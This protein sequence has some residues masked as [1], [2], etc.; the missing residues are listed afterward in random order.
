MG[1]SRRGAALPRSRSR[2]IISPSSLISN[3][4]ACL[5]CVRRCF[6][7]PQQLC[8]GVSCLLQRRTFLLCILQPPPGVLQRLGRAGPSGVCFLQPTQTQASSSSEE[9]AHDGELCVCVGLEAAGV[10]SRELLPQI[11]LTKHPATTYSRCIQEPV[12]ASG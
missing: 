9:T 7:L 11:G 8:S 5:Q 10:L 1:S 12:D 3:S 6:L 2:N 4:N